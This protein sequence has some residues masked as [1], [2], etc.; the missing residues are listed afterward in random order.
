VL[1]EDRGMHGAAG[2]ET[3]S[4]SPAQTHSDDGVDDGLSRVYAALGLGVIVRLL[5]STSIGRDYLQTAVLPFIMMQ[6]A[7]CTYYIYYDK[8]TSRNLPVLSLLQLYG[9]A[10]E[11]LHSTR[12]VLGLLLPVFDDFLYYFFSFLVVH[13]FID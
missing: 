1:Q 11:L 3:S 12:R 13:F 9:V 6:V 7:L 5:L 10:P 2:S 8:I 4:H